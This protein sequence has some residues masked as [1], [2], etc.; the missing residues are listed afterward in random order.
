MVGDRIRFYP[1]VC[2]EAAAAGAPAED[3]TGHGKN[4]ADEASAGGAFTLSTAVDA[5]GDYDLCNTNVVAFAANAMVVASAFVHAAA[6]TEETL[7]LRCY[8][9]GVEVAESAY[10]SQGAAVNR[11]AVG[12]KDV[13]SGSNIIIKASVHNYGGGSENFERSAPADGDKVDGAVSYGS[14]KVA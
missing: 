7:K 3:V 4:T 9:D 12:T 13:S 2:E 14:I 6:D 1:A 8:V 11:V 10:I 5:A